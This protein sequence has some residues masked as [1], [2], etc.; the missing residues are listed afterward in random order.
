MR[1][2]S[3]RFE[4]S[5]FSAAQ[6]PRAPGPDVVFFG[7]SNVGK[8]SLINRLLGVKG[9]ARTSSTP[10]RTQSVNFYRINERIWF[11]DLPGYGFAKVPQAVREAW[12]PMIEGVLERRQERLAAAIQIV[13]ARHD[14]TSLDRAMRDWLHAADAPTILVATKSDK[15]SGNAKA[16]ARK[17]L[18]SFAAEVSYVAA[19]LLVSS[20][21]GDGIADLWRLID[22]CLDEHGATHSGPQHPRPRETH[23]NP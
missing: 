18:K 20:Q 11:V 16:K 4:I 2:E 13:D 5:A 3:S 21:T 12:Q 14:P 1:V 7:R 6:E 15:L 19:P 23:G 9:L 17:T 10:G 22:G 8:S